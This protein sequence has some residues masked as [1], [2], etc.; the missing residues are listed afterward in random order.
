VIVSEPLVV[1]AFS[2][3]PRDSVRQRVTAG[4]YFP[5]VILRSGDLGVV[6]TVQDI[7][8]KRMGFTWW[9]FKEN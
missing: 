8:G 2:R 9:K 3:Q 4:E 1:D 7:A 6:T 5:A